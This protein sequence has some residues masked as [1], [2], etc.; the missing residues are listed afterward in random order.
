MG[1]S[2]EGMKFMSNYESLKD[3]KHHNCLLFVFI[4]APIR[5]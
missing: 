2:K 1:K 4:P 5:T 3:K